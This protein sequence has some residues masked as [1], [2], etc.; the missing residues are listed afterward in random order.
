MSEAEVE[1]LELKE[2][3]EK[4]ED[5]EHQ[6]QNRIKALEQ[7][8]SESKAAL[9]QAAI[10]SKKQAEEHE[11]ALA[12]SDVA[13]DCR[14]RGYLV[15]RPTGIEQSWCNLGRE[16]ERGRWGVCGI[17]GAMQ[18]KLTNEPCGN[19]SKND[20]TVY[21][22]KRENARSLLRDTASTADVAEVVGI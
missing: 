21:A 4:A 5:E 9:D 11:R 1:I 8:I 19:Q 7:Q 22:Q 14:Y 20:R 17:D 6:A 18:G 2:A 13:N 16:R 10:E 15:T 3:A 12:K